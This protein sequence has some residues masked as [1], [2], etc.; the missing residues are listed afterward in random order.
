MTWHLVLPILL[1]LT[2]WS[3]TQRFLAHL[4]GG[5]GAEVFLVGKH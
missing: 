4:V 3:H 1:S 2:I 5:E